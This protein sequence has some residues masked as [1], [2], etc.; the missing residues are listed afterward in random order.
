[1]SIFKNNISYVSSIFFLNF[2]VFVSYYLSSVKM[3]YTFI[4]SILKV[5]ILTSFFYIFVFY[6]LCFFLK[7]NKA[8][9][10]IIFF[11]L[12]NYLSGIY[13]EYNNLFIISFIICS[14]LNLLFSKNL[15][16]ESK[17]YKFIM[18]FSL[19]YISLLLFSAYQIN[20]YKNK[21]FNDLKNQT[22]YFEQTVESKSDRN[23]YI[24]L[25]DGL[26]NSDELKKNFNYDLNYE[27]TELQNR[28]ILEH[29]NHDGTDFTTLHFVCSLLSGNYNFYY[30]DEECIKN[31][32][33]ETKLIDNLKKENYSF[34]FA[35]NG[36]GYPWICGN[37]VDY[38]IKGDSFSMWEIQYLK[39]SFFKY[40]CNLSFLKS[41]CHHSAR[42]FVN[43]ETIINSNI[44]FKKKHLF[45]I[46]LN[47]PHKNTN[48]DINCNYDYQNTWLN[49]KFYNSFNNDI[50]CLFKDLNKLIDYIYENNSKTPLV[51]IA[52]DTS[53]VPSE[54]KDIRYNHLL[55][56]SFWASNSHLFCNSDVPSSSYDL[57]YFM[58]SCLD[59]KKF[60]SREKIKFSKD[61]IFRH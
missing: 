44:N 59:N 31:Y 19:V 15:K 36:A 30:T 14:L 47:I 39:K 8:F 51:F 61:Y 53:T 24:I 34:Y 3:Q 33:G 41:F 11:I 54:K 9:W 16:K 49:K 10:I 22:K 52:T 48:Y 55:T 27:L 46:H 1:M 50:K 43:V 12:F 2:S 26:P 18:F 28:N 20:I 21:K 32:R 17:I 29:I 7:K 58:I 23:L 4:N 5:S 35:E 37:S 57:L 6:I 45:F 42:N 60:Y 25:P 13:H 56:R 38:C 40:L